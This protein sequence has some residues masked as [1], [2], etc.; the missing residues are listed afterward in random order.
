[1][2]LIQKYLILESWT[3]GDTDPWWLSIVQNIPENTRGIENIYGPSI[4]SKI[5]KL[6]H[7][8]LPLHFPIK[9]TLHNSYKN[10]SVK[11]VQMRGE[12]NIHHKTFMH[13]LIYLHFTN[14]FVEKWPF[15]FYVVNVTH[16]TLKL[17]QSFFQSSNHQRLQNIYYHNYWIYYTFCFPTG[18]HCHLKNILLAMYLPIL[19]IKMSETVLM[20]IKHYRSHLSLVYGYNLKSV[21]E[22]ASMTLSVASST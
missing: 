12:K 2:F 18:E 1:M 10:F 9:F 22:V 7:I 20:D 5:L 11:I 13:Y 14:S 8:I 19:G 16:V 3:R 4:W 15:S 21:T 6:Y 17:A